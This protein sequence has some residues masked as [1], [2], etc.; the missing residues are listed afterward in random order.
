MATKK[1]Q[2]VT[3][4]DP[5]PG[6]DSASYFNRIMKLRPKS[7]D[8]G[9]A[10]YNVFVS[11]QMAFTRLATEKLSRFFP[12]EYDQYVQEGIAF[13]EGYAA[14]RGAATPSTTPAPPVTTPATTRPPTTSTPPTTRPPTGT[15]P[16]TTAPPTTRPTST[17]VPPTTTPPTTTPPTTGTT[18]PTIKDIYGA[19]APP[20]TT[21]TGTTT[22]PPYAP[23]PR[24]AKDPN[25]KWYVYEGPG[26]V[27]LDGQI[28]EIY[29]DINN[30]PGRFYAGMAPAERLEVLGK[31]N[32]SGFY[33]AGNIGNYASDLNAI[34][35]WLEYSNNAG[36]DREAALNQIVSTGATMPKTGSGGTPRTYKTSNTDDLKVMAKKISQDTLGRMMSDE[37][38][39]R[40][41]ATYQQSEIDYQKSMYAGATTED[42][43]SADI[44]AQEFSQELAPTEAN[45]YKYLGYV[46]K[47]FNSIG[48]L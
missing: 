14:A 24:Y 21:T 7:T 16:P 47:F 1:I 42:M 18:V 39:S 30:D 3:I 17:T 37:E 41:V 32:D 48:G 29:Y 38:L 11:E 43:Q 31:L 28:S 45:A 36:L 10:A 6:E 33:T 20:G 44:A 35:A 13:Q 22:V 34:S 12:A 46:D 2:T 15:M 25:G 8:Y 26:L 40:F 4:P 5:K 27:T 9:P 23:P 19:D